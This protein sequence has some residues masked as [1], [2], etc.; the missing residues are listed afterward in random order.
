MVAVLE[1][2]R[3]SSPSVT[4]A[5]RPE[6]P[7]VLPDGDVLIACDMRAADAENLF[8]VASADWTAGG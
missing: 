3:C 4:D 5:D 6:G 8:L 2:P 1:A 7:V